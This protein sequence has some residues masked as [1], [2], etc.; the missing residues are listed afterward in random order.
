MRTLSLRQALRCETATCKRCK[1]RC[2]GT[3]HGALRGKDDNFVEQ[4]PKDDPHFALSP[5][6]RRKLRKRQMELFE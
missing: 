1:C 5:Q 2:G 6:T 4:L 3:L